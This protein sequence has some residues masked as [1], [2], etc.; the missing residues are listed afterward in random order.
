MVIIQQCLKIAS[1]DNWDSKD[2]ARGIESLYVKLLVEEVRGILDE[3]IM[4]IKGSSRWGDLRVLSCLVSS[5]TGDVQAVI[6]CDT[7]CYSKFITQM[8][9]NMAIIKKGDIGLI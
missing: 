9:R 8:E 7:S 5:L 3:T 1:I 2:K 4:G 6:A